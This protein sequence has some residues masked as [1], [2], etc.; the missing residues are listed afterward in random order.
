MV[1]KLMIFT[2]NIIGIVKHEVHGDKYKKVKFL[3]KQLFF[4]SQCI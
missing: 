1:L 4:A 3:P 2:I